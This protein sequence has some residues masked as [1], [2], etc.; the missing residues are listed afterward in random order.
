MN[1]LS[2]RY[3]RVD[4]D[5]KKKLEGQSKKQVER[6][7]TLMN[8]IENINLKIVDLLERANSVQ[9]EVI[10]SEEYAEVK[11]LKMTNSKF[12]E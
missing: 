3:S 9:K 7:G 2:L 1:D 4:Q 11:M 6:M 5:Q 10:E 12:H 8:E